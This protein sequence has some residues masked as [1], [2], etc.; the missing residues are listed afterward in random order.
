MSV[1]RICANH[2]GNRTHQ[3]REMMYGMGERFDYL[4][5]QR[6]RLPADR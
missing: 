1:C 3:V 6:L 2:E 4:R 5:V